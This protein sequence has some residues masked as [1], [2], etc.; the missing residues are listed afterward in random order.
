MARPRISETASSLY[1][2]I[3]IFLIIRIWYINWRVSFQPVG[4]IE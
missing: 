1:S 2:Q 4:V 3:G